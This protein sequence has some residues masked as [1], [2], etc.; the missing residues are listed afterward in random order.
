MNCTHTFE[1]FSPMIIAV[2]VLFAAAV[3]LPAV[4]Q[5]AETPA[6]GGR[7]GVALPADGRH[8]ARQPALKPH[9]LAAHPVLGR[10]LPPRRPAHVQVYPPEVHCL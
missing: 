3:L 8:R 1:F 4:R 10:D 6:R 5:L 7:G 2:P 9:R